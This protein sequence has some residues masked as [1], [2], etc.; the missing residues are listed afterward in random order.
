M[1]LTEFSKKMARSGYPEGYRA[2]VIK[3]GVLGFERQLEASR[4][5]V[6]PLFRPREWQKAERRKKKM[7]KVAAWYRP[8][9]CV[10]FYPPT[11]R[12]ELVSEIGKVLKEEG[13]RINM[14]L[15]AVETGGLS[16]GK[17]LVRP[18]LRA[19]EPCG[20]PGCVL[21]KCSGGAG[22]PHNVPSVVYRGIC[23]LCGAEE[24][25][26]EYWGESAF[27]GAFR[28]GMHE[29]DVRSKKDTNAFYK[30]LEIFHPEVQA[31]IEFF[32]IQVQ[33]VHKK[34]LS[35]Q[36]TEAVKIATSTADN[37]LNSKAE[38]R[39]PALL[40]V[41]MVRGDDGEGQDQPRRRGRG[42]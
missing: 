12:G 1:I 29:G 41:R 20:R 19:G 24:L 26:S 9:D 40:R 23:K 15:R 5:G 18:D 36:K 13:S 32:D 21:D 35:R 6:K 31:N 3:S 38:H 7:V 30:H 33:S 22:G 37:L 34:T 11:P 2:E 17:Q 28:T 25:T 42:E 39:Q 16:I 8:A 14:D 27:S 10:G 4:S